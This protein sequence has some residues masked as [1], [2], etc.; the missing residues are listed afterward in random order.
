MQNS[1][2]ELVTVSQLLLDCASNPKRQPYSKPS[3]E[4]ITRDQLAIKYPDMFVQ[5]TVAFSDR[6]EGCVA[7]TPSYPME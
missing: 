6:W 3:A 4:T 2:S 7:P 5:N 1:N